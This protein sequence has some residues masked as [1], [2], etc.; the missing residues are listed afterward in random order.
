M[1]IIAS[2]PQGLESQLAQEIITLGGQNVQKKRR[3]VSFKSNYETFYKLHFC[4]RIAFRFYR[5]I[6][7]FSCFNKETLYK[8][9]QDSF[10][11]LKWLPPNKSFC[12]QVSGGSNSLNHSHFNALQ[13]KNSIVD[14]QKSV[15]GKRSNISLE[16]PYLV[17]HLHLNNKEAVLSLQSTTESL[18]KRGYRPSIGNAPL[19]ENLAAG[20]IQ[21]TKWDGSIPLIDIMCGSGTFLIEAAEQLLKKPLPFKKKYLFENWIDFE[22]DLF[23]KVKSNININ[24]I[25]NIKASKIIGCEINDVVYE[26]AIENINLAD[27]SELIDIHNIDFSQL[28]INS[29]LNVNSQRGIIVCNPPY[30]KKLGRDRKELIE[31]YEKIGNSLKDKFSGWEFWLLSGNPELTQYLKMKSCLKIPVSNGGIDCRWIKY[32]IR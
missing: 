6:A 17:I 5:E 8:G 26:Q 29:Q 11:W 18:H 20:L 25:K 1:N 21:I 15:L 32:E 3:Y 27:L 16:N 7:R 31:L 13:V 22:L 12:V 24:T 30:G 9:V 19:K 28:N 10:E 4:S 14:L 23:K 2:S